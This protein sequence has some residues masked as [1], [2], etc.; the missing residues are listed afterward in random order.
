MRQQAKISENMWEECCRETQR[1]TWEV[2]LVA[3]GNGKR[4]MVSGRAQLFGNHELLWSQHAPVIKKSDVCYEVQDLV[5]FEGE[6][7][8]GGQ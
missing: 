5:Y 6:R 8:L 2:G 7:E 3:E 4:T 1:Q